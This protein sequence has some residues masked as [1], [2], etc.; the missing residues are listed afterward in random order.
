MKRLIN[1]CLLGWMVSLSGC[2][3]IAKVDEKTL[4]TELQER[5]IDY[6]P[7]TDLS[8]KTGRVI[9]RTKTPVQPNVSTKQTILKRL[10]Q[11]FDRELGKRPGV[12][13]DRK[14]GQTVKDEIELSELYGK[15]SG[16]QDAD[17]VMMLVLDSYSSDTS[18]EQSTALISRKTYFDC[19]YEAAY[20]G[21]V[22]V[23]VMPSL[24]V[25]KQWAI[26]ESASD[27][28]DGA[29]RG[30]CQRKFATKLQELHGKMVEHTVCTSK[31]DAMNALA[32]SGHVLSLQTTKEGMRLETSLN[33]RMQVVKGD[34]ILFYHELTNQPFAEGEVASINDSS[35][36]VKL[37][38]M[39]KNQRV[40]RGD[41]VRPNYSGLI[42]AV[43]CLF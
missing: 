25:I 11:T 42:N 34:K 23:Y 5:P 38:R 2:S 31:I 19:E 39:E 28:F 41:W 16:R 27:S 24:A 26:D 36:W 35:A 14:L 33:N 30:E 21:W 20:K 9:I 32:P 7:V 18:S 37:D 22:R 6:A 8:G 12:V 3:Q 13:V 17:Y 43:K 29:N 1:V 15:D 4:Q 40:Y 10:E